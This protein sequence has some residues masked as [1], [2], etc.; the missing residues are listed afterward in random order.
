MDWKL[1][2]GMNGGEV[3]RNLP[4]FFRKET[5]KERFILNLSQETQQHEAGPLFAFVRERNVHTL[6]NDTERNGC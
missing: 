6:L 5:E 2:D 1:W 3:G 4:G